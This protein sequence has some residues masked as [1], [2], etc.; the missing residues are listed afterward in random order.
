M[1][2]E[3]SRLW[4]SVS[5]RNR[6]HRGAIVAALVLLSLLSGCL[7]SDPTENMSPADA[8]RFRQ[9]NGYCEM[10]AQRAFPRVDPRLD[11]N[12]RYNAMIANRN[13]YRRSCLNAKGW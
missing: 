1:T 7:T 11:V 4:T 13:Q 10:Q 6:S 8:A 5:R 12:V 2:S 3:T 9:D